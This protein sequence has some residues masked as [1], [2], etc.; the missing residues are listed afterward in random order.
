MK[1]SARFRS[2]HFIGIGGA[3]MSALAEVMVAWGFQVSGSDKQDG[4]VVERLRSLGIRVSIGHAAEHI[5]KADTV[6]YSSAVN[7]ENP[8]VM[9]AKQR[10]IPLIRRA[11]MMGE[12]MRGSYALG[13]AGTHGKTTT[14]TMLA[15]IWMQAGRAPT[16]LA[17]GVTRGENLAA[18]SGSGDALIFEADEFDRSFLAMRPSAAIIGNVDSDHLDCYGTLGAIEDAFVD[19]ANSMPFY[20]LAVVNGDDVGVRS[21][22]PRILIPC[23]TYGMGSGVYRPNLGGTLEPLTYRAQGLQTSVDGISFELEQREK[24]LGRIHLSIPGNHNVFNA[25]AAAA[26]SLE[27]GIAFADV[28]SGLAGFQ[29]VKRRMELRGVEGGVAVYDDYAHHPTEVAATLQA[30][31]SLGQGRVMAVFQPHLYSRTQQLFREFAQSFKDCDRLFVMPIY[32]SREKAMPGVTS[33]LISDAARSGIMRPEC[34]HD[35]DNPADLPRVMRE[36]VEPGDIIVTLGAGDIG[37]QCPRILE[38]LA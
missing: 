15:R 11:E 22:L 36:F 10:V 26:L 6:V 37:N 3:G 18:V 30:A 20:G 14:T 35:V 12:I 27:E 1:P 21:I 13:V 9:E 5:G 16:V 8:E 31:R 2:L 32:A 25:L 34:V 4:E 17:G 7:A 24:I 23:V 33:Q 29:G 38:A 19:F 28:Q